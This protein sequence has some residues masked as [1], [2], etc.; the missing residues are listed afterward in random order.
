M[1]IEPEDARSR[2]SRDLTPLIG[3][4]MGATVTLGEMR[5]RVVAAT[6]LVRMAKNQ[7]QEISYQGV[8]PMTLDVMAN[9]ATF[10]F[11]TQAGTERNIASGQL[12]VL[13]TATPKRVSVL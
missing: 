7:S 6:M 8:G 11:C 10:I 1:P 9:R 13:A 4:L 12:H 3:R 2:Q 5:R